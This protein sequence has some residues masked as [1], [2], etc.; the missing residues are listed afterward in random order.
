L[1]LAQQKLAQAE[2]T[3]LAVEKQLQSEI[4]ELEKEL[5]DTRSQKRLSENVRL[6]RNLFLKA[7]TD[8]PTILSVPQRSS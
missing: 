4:D 2:A 5:M 3:N 1:D 6:N 7:G 8:K